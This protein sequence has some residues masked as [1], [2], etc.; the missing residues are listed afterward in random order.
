MRELRTLGAIRMP[1]QARQLIEAVYS[2]EASDL[3]P[4]A[5]QNQENTLIGEERSKVAKAKS[6]LID[7]QYGYCDRSAKA[8]HDDDADISTRYS[9]IETVE[10]LLLKRDDAGQLRPW[11]DTEEFAIQLST[12]KLSKNKYADKLVRLEEAEEE[13]FK[14]QHRKAKYLQCW[15]PEDDRNFT[16]HPATGFCEQQQKDTP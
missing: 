10:V 3:I 7:W 14:A 1:S 6:Q 2:D 16:Y 4:E 12:L 5:L 9:D 15:V 8:W 11:A 13:T